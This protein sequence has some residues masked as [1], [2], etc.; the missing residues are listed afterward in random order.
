MIGF[1]PLI[2]LLAA[3]V[4]IHT[5]ISRPAFREPLVA[6]LG[7]GGYGTVHGIVSVL[8][9]AAV[10]WAFFRAP[11]LELWPSS[12]A[13]RAVPALAMPLACILAVAS[14]T[15]PYAGLSGD[16][17]PEGDNQAP[18]ILGLTRHPAPWALILWGAAHVVANGDLAG[19]LFFGTFL[20]FAA[21]A[22]VLVDSRRRRLCG[23]GAWSR[24]AAATSTTPFF[25]AIRNHAKI[26][27]RGIGWTPLAIG[28]ALYGAILLIHGTVF[29]VAAIAPWPF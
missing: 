4:A 28:L 16:R 7:R 11:Y 22:P 21:F 20:V 27:W 19:L 12:A 15:N 23:E 26:D 5:V 14:I 13:L 2:T 10:F 3:F 17:L 6:R 1:L 8:G 18:G 25:S 29:G 9:M 24:F